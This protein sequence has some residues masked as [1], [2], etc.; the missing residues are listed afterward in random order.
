[1]TSERKPVLSIGVEVGAGVEPIKAGAGVGAG[2]EAGARGDKLLVGFSSSLT[3]H[4]TRFLPCDLVRLRL[5]IGSQ[6]ANSLTCF[7]TGTLELLFP[8]ELSSHQDGYEVEGN[9][10]T[11]SCPVTSLFEGSE[12]VVVDAAPFKQWYL[13]HY[14]VDI[15]RKKKTSAAAKKDKEGDAPSEEALDPHIEEQFSSG[16]LMACIS[17]RP[18]QCGRADGFLITSNRKHAEE[19]GKGRKEQEERKERSR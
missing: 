16:R 6:S 19:Q 14:G 4:L 13:Q 2:A 7:Q 3:A 5:R 12:F 18:G 15:G 1:M 11:L 10:P 8:E 17:S 9:L